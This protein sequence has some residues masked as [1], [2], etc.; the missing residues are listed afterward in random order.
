M[1]KEVGLT[2]DK[3]I[4]ISD[5]IEIDLEKGEIRLFGIRGVIIDP[6]SCCKRIDK[7]LGSGGEVVIHNMWF[8]QGYTVF[9]EMIENNSEKTRERLLEQ[10]ARAQPINGWGKFSF[11]IVRR[12]SPLVEITA[13]NPP[14]KTLKGSAKRLVSSFW[15]GVFSKYFERSVSSE[16]FEYDAEKDE[17]KFVLSG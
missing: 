16:N 10:L 4:K 14:F 17:F 3:K 2:K 13:E 8:E 7:M 11:A 15:E 12:D 9:A 6:I 1:V 5:G